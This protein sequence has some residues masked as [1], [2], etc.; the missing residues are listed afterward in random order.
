M[1][2]SGYSVKFGGIDSFAREIIRQLHSSAVIRQSSA[3]SHQ[4]SSISDHS[5][6]IKPSAVE[7]LG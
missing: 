3:I 2:G 6:A 5:S 7:M 4:R 1:V